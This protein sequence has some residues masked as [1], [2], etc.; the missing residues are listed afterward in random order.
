[1]KTV[2][3]VLLRFGAIAAAILGLAAQYAWGDVLMR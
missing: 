1:M 2:T 3:E